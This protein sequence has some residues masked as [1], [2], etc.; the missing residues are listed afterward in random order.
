MRYVATERSWNGSAYECV[1]CHRAYA[2]LPDLNRH[3][4]SAAHDEKLFRCPRASDGCGPRFGTVSALVQ[5]VE[6]GSCGVRR[7]QR[8]LAGVMDELTNGMRLL[9]C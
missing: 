1:L 2:R 6:T 9:T 5:H 8:Q 4:A 7:F 3:L